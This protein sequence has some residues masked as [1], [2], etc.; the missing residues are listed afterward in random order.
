MMSGYDVIISGRGLFILLYWLGFSGVA[1]DPAKAKAHDSRRPVQ[2][3][4][5]GSGR[6]VLR[7]SGLAE[8]SSGVG[9]VPQ[10][11]FLNLFQ[12]S[13]DKYIV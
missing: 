11:Y 12:N 7:I 10:K 5:G 9:G 6:T 3:T 4:S 8:V 2:P 13:D 1:G